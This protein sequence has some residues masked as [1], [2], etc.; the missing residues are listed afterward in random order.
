MYLVLAFLLAVFV[1]ASVQS[2]SFADA[3]GA[4]LPSNMNVNNPNTSVPEIITPQTDST[5]T[6]LFEIS[7]TADPGVFVEVFA[8]T[9]SL[10]KTPSDSSG[11]WSISVTAPLS[12][13]I[14]TLTAMAIDGFGNSSAL[15]GD[16]SVT[17]T[18]QLGTISGTIFV[19]RTTPYSG[20][21]ITVEAKSKSASVASTFTVT[22]AAGKYSF[23]DLIAGTSYSILIKTP[24]YNHSLSS[25]CTDFRSYM[26]TAGG[27]QTANCMI[28]LVPS[29]TSSITGSV[30]QDDNGNGLQN[31][32]EVGI[33][34][35]SVIAIT[36]HGTFK[37]ATTDSDGMY[38]ITGLESST[39]QILVQTL[40]SP[41]AN[42]D[43]HSRNATVIQTGFLPDGYLATS[44]YY[45]F[46]L[47]FQPHNFPQT[48]DFALDK[49]TPQDESVLRGTVYED[50]NTNNTHDPGEPGL[51]DIEIIITE[52]SSGMTHTVM[53]DSDGNYNLEGLMPYKVSVMTGQLPN[54]HLHVGYNPDHS[55]ELA[56]GS[57]TVLDFPTRAITPQDTVT[58]SGIVFRDYNSN[59]VHESGEPGISDVLV[60]AHA[61]TPGQTESAMTNTDGIFEITNVLPDT[62]RVE[63]VAPAGFSSATSNDGMAVHDFSDDD[64]WMAMFG[65]KGTTISGTVFSDYDGNGIQD[66]VDSGVSTTVSVGSVSVMTDDAGGYTI[67]G[68]LPGSHTVEFAIPSEY[69]VSGDSSFSVTVKE[70]QNTNFDLPLTP[71]S[72]ITGTIYHDANGNG[73][74]DSGEA[75]IQ[76]SI[77]VGDITVQSDADGMYVISGLQAGDYTIEV[78]APDTHTAPTPVTVSVSA[79]QSETADLPLTPL[80]TITGTI[81]HDANGNGM[82][83]SGEAGIQTSITVGD[84]TV[85]SDADGMYVISG[86]QA[87]DYTIEV[88]APDTHT[89]PTPVTVSV[90]ADQSETADLPLTPVSVPDFVTLEISAYNDNNW[91]RMRNGSD[92]AYSGLMLLTYTPNTQEV[93]LLFTDS[94]GMISASL[95][96]DSFW[97]ISLPPDGKV[98]ST[99]LH[100]LDNTTY[101][102]VLYV[103]NPAPG[104]THLMEIGIQDDPCL[105][106]PPDSIAAVFLECRY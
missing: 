82:Q 46:I 52:L 55:H 87:G 89:A 15:S 74:Q 92:D 37:H 79:G 35:I 106:I 54:D 101:K 8:G 103:E 9:A 49:I 19:D 75:G 29:S 23:D 17:V 39:M 59:G 48:V 4:L 77:T 56:S 32:G 36:G 45:K 47:A 73:M 86:L 53:T 57:T 96:V 78:T 22:D 61:M 60:H 66:E 11:A 80:S 20:T 42:T 50:A 28:S 51:A 34:G 18:D 41:P 27:V 38:E 7:G 12:P 99:H 14:H 13:G 83:D 71:L 72:T 64:A 2:Q 95:T 81:Y 25:G 44:Q 94:D 93:D 70:N 105:F 62:V 104:S 88:T 5:L 30:F 102:G 24:G 98:A 85:Q 91:D 26:V 63:A 31:I 1:L 68:L 10:G 6:P 58:V 84:I 97:V 43:D 16:I 33:S 69:T 76:T 21:P 90:S 65:F 40:G 100:T 67:A 3:D